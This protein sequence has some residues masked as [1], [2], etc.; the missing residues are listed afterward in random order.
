MAPIS[1][2]NTTDT[3]DNALVVIKGGTDNTSIG[4]SGNRLLVDSNNNPSASELATFMVVSRG[5][6]IANGKSMLSIVNTTG[7]TVKVKI[8]QIK[9]INV[10]NTAVTGVIANFE[11]R[12]FVSHASGTLLTSLPMD[13]ADSISASVTSRTGATITGETAD[14]M[15]RHSYSTDEW[16]VGTLDVEAH[17]HAIQQHNPIYIT[18]RNAKPITLNAN[19]GFHIKQTVA[20]SVG[21][22]D[23]E[24]IFTQE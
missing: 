14:V 23:I 2:S 6:G 19:Q 10:Q 15:F 1:D 3:F 8:R 21:T 9:V 7:S 16:G 4:N 20:S 18:P 22:F 24:V 13:T 11:F 5:T 17:D 12:R